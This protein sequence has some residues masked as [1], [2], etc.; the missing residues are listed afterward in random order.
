VGVFIVFLHDWEVADLYIIC[1]S[2]NISHFGH[3]LCK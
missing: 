3:L 1:P 2:I